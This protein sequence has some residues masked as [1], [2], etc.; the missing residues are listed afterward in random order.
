M[1]SSKTMPQ[2][3]FIS[4]PGSRQPCKT[5][6][7]S[8]GLGKASL[9]RTWGGDQKKDGVTQSQSGSQVTEPCS[10]GEPV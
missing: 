3:G 9:G 4:C 7:L 10:H 5:I 2:A 6:S 8:S 1:A